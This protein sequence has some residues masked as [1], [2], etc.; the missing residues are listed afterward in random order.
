MWKNIDSALFSSF[1]NDH[2][3][4]DRT[5]FTSIYIF[6]LHVKTESVILSR[7]AEEQ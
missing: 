5:F 6:L 7:I 3:R 2:C 1:K 4:Y